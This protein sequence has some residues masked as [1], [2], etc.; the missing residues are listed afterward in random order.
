MRPGASS[1]LEDLNRSIDVSQNTSSSIPIPVA[2]AGS[3]RAEIGQSQQQSGSSLHISPVAP[4]LHDPVGSSV[5]PPAS[6]VLI[7]GAKAADNRFKQFK[8]S[9][10]NCCGEHHIECVRLE[11]PGSTRLLSLAVKNLVLAFIRFQFLK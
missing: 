6:T 5:P 8:G 3:G 10:I 11:S 4:V 1:H 2:A 9:C 7:T